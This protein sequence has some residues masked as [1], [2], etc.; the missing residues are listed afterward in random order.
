MTATRAIR[1]SWKLVC[2]FGL[3]AL[4]SHMHAQATI[5]GTINICTPVTSIGCNQLSVASA[6]GFAAG[7]RVLVIQMKGA[8]IDT[9]NAPQFGNIIQ[10]NNSGNYEF[11]TIASVSGNTI[12]LNFSLVNTYSVPGLV[13]LVRVPQYA[14]VTVSPVLSCPAWNG[15]TGGVLVLEA[16]GI[17]TLNADIDVSG[18]GFRGGTQCTNPDGNCGS[19]Y[20]DY[21]YAVSSGFGAEKGEGIAMVS[22]PK[23]GGR[24]ALGSGGGG[25]NK[26]NSGGG[27]G[28]N[29]SAGGHGGNEANFCPPTA[30][31]GDGG[32]GLD[33]ATQHK[34]FLGGGGGCSDN[35][36]GVGTPGTNGGG[37]I[38]I[39]A[40]GIQSGNST[41]RLILANGIDQ[42][43]IPNGIGDGSGGGGAGG[44]ILLDVPNMTGDIVIQANGGAGGGQNCTYGSCFGPG[45]GGGSG[46]IGISAAALSFGTTAILGVGMPGLDV[47]PGSPCYNT[48]YGATGGQ[49]SPNMQTG[50]VFIEGHSAGTGT[51]NAGSSK[52]ICAGDSV[53]IGTA[54]V[55]GLNYSWTPQ[56]SLSSASVSDPVAFPAYTTTYTLTVNSTSGNCAETASVLVTVV[57]CDT[58]SSIHIPNVFTPNGDGVNDH[59]KISASGLSIHCSIYN[60]WGQKL[61]EWS[62]TDGSWNGKGPQGNE[63]PDGT[64][65][66]I[67]EVS[68]Y[69]VNKTYKGFLTLGR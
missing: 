49:V 67:L 21:Y 35:N 20:S 63:A 58:L 22:S 42:V 68:G 65:Y 14:N 55:S 16:S 64:Y 38:I 12:Y 57:T 8:A 3:I 6:A 47:N 39:R 13:Q 56:G 28:G 50:Y 18:K 1:K 23:R 45:G 4:G 41:T 69:K 7:D 17:L 46:F 48:S 44:A 5:G 51:V 62:G 29:Y 34:V 9:A 2:L 31:G 33:Y 24:G 40:A 52:T 54:P 43:I 19:G 10:Y 66:Y 36:N 60:R 53:M 37:I 61:Y 59:F 25:G 27:G 30:V 26:H 32:K 11:A 15:S